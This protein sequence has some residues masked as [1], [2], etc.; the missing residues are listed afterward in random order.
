MFAGCGG[1]SKAVETTAP[2]K[3]DA[4]KPAGAVDINFWRP[5][6]GSQEE[7]DYYVKKVEQ[8]NKEYSGKINLKMEVITRGNSFAYEDKINAAV[9]SNTLPD[10]MSIDGPNMANYAASKI[11]VPIDEY[12][13]KDEMSDF[14]PSLTQQGTY[15]G[16]FYSV[17]MNESS[18]VLFYNK[19]IMKDNGIEPPTSIDKAWT[20]DDWYN[21]M[22]KTA[23]NGIMGT[24]M[25]NDKGEWMPYCFEQFWISNGTDL[26]NKEGTQAEGYVNGEKGLEAA[27][28]LAKLAKEKLFNI[29]PTPTE[30][31]EGKAATKLG[32]PW[33]IPG[34]KNFPNLDWGMTYYPKKAGGVQTAPSG[35]WA[36]AVTS[37]SKHPKEAVEVI[38]YFTG[39]KN[40][41]EFSKTIA[42]PAGSKK[43][44]ES[45]PEYNE[46]P[47]KVV[48]EQVTQVSH[49]RP[50]TPAYP[51]LSQKFAEALTN[52]MMG[53][54]VKKSLDGVA[55]AYDDEYKKNYVS[56]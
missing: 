32:G 31:E 11:I 18:V 35:S 2:S 48:K 45:L 26:V 46:L 24:N 53:A 30:F 4:A 36:L 3:T 52:I 12:Y 51:V 9:A 34:F 22:K 28:F 27:N 6:G 33:N 50:V 56:K 10:I 25:I 43:A 23:K 39:A 1:K 17:G 19:K 7:N 44:F 41:A 38:K 29:D 13:T 15:N 20:W 54:D 37:G 55:K 47:L 21:V 16:K 8:F 14:V 42:M 5:Q 40:S 49:A